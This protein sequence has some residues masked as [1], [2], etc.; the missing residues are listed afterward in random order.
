MLNY[1]PSR[2]K[3]SMVLK[4]AR[5]DKVGYHIIIFQPKET[6]STEMKF[7]RWIVVASA[8][9]SLFTLFATGVA[10]AQDPTVTTEPATDVTC[11]SATLN[12]NLTSIGN[13]TYVDVYFDWGL[14]TGYGNTT[15][16]GNLTE[17]GTFSAAINGL[18]PST[19][20]HF[21]ARATDGNSTYTGA[22][23]TFT[24]TIYLYLEGW[25]WCTSSGEV[26]P[27]T[28]EGCTTMVER[29]GASNSY[30]MHTTGNLTLPAPYDETITLDMYGS[31]VRSL[32]YLRQEVTG[33]SATFEGT[34]LEGS[35]N[36][37]YIALSGTVAL[38][39]SEGEVLKTAR[40][41]FAMLRTSDVEVPIAEPG[42]FAEDV[43]SM[44][45]RFVKLV[46]K[47]LDSL[48]GTGFSDILSNI[49]SK[50]MVIIANIRDL[51]TPYMP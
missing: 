48:I 29:T 10:S 3:P 30:S 28:F 2:L 43:E 40:I 5:F 17:A 41:C 51:G 47:V 24:T 44:L 39:N 16:A 6:R 15:S 21:V 45:S 1:P 8:F 27:I 25:G 49:L 9:L 32:F 11:S 18:S 12:G 31:R 13:A 19:T 36:E 7:W 34:W 14:D 42:S 22:D 38:P 20:Y 50:I 4:I 37:T 33:K 26:V 35:G 46:D 23:M